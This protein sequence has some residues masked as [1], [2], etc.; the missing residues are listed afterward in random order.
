MPDSSNFLVYE[1]LYEQMRKKLIELIE[2]EHLNYLPNEKELM[3]RYHVSRN[4]LRRAIL[5]LTKEGIL[6]PVQGIGTLVHPASGVV[7]GSS[8]LLLCDQRIYGYQ[9]EV[10]NKL[11]Y[12]MGQSNLR[13]NVLMLDKENVNRT[14]VE[15]YI[16]QCDAIILDL[17]CSFSPV[18][19]DLAAKSG[20]KR[21]CLRWNATRF[22][23][24]SVETD[25]TE[26]AYQ[27]MKHLLAFGHRNIVYLGN[28]GDDPQ[29]QP[30]IERALTEF[31]MSPSDLAY[32]DIPWTDRK[33]NDRGMG[34]CLT[35]RI[36][37]ERRNFTAIFA[38]N[39]LLALGAEERLLEAGLKI[40]EDVSITGFDNLSDSQ[41]FPVPLTTCSGNT[42][43]MIHEAIAYLF[44]TRRPDDL[45]YKKHTAE[46]VIRQSTGPVKK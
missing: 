16:K 32:Y 5:E 13:A 12:L 35:S 43:D 33:E 6:Q 34:Y 11:L 30:G 37:A 7:S 22:N 41:Y 40:P 28:S 29:R 3:T 10:F 2:S 18:L 46:I 24:S 9:Q 25:I 14:L 44:S 36:L 27:L 1:P 42:D 15:S 20:K 19:R 38:N 17:H 31:G 8:V 39:D 21:I 26:G 45:F 4:T 23:L